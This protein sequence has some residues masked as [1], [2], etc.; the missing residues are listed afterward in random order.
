[1]GTKKTYKQSEAS[2]RQD[3]VHLCHYHHAMV[4]RFSTPNWPDFMITPKNKKIFFIETK[5]SSTGYGLTEGQEAVIE[6]LR[7]RGHEVLVL[8]PSQL[9][10][11]ENYII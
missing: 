11:I 5:K 7:S 2:F 1:M 6:L 3:I 10:S 9:D 4:A 8:I